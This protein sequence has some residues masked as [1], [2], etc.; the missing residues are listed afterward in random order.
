MLSPN[1]WDE[2]AGDL[3]NAIYNHV[4]YTVGALKVHFDRCFTPKLGN[5]FMLTMI[6]FLPIMATIIVYVRLSEC[7]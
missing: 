5:G 7:M 4:I 2:V 3:W 6:L 1:M